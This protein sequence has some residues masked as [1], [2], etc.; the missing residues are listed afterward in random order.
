MALKCEN[1]HGIL[2]TETDKNILL[3]RARCKQWTCAY[4]AQKNRQI[5]RARIIDFINKN[6]TLN[7]SWFTL[8]AHS[9]KRGANASLK[10]LRDVWQKLI[11]RIQRHFKDVKKI[12]YVRVFEP[13][14]DNS[15]HLHCIISVHW[16]DIKTRKSRKKDH[17]DTTYGKWLAKTA[18]DLKI[19]Y[20]T[21]AAN[22]EG[23]HAGYIAGYVV[24]YM[25]KISREQK[26]EIGRIR[27]IQTSQGWP[28]WKPEAKHNW[29]IT[30]GI[31]ERDLRHS[32]EIQKPIFDLSESRE[33]TSDDFLDGYVY[34]SID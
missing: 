6:D 31:F 8:T 21:H 33:I 19:G 30:V 4:C 20:Y 28:K 25:T 12:H 22:F 26:E 16:D 1:F 14:K 15:Y 13:H 18:K 27:H 29:S 10:N 11:Q 17:A 32:I 23:Q 5:W 24:K 2:T 34:P 9:K 7:W 3:A